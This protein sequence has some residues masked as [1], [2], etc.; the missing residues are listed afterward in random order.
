MKFICR[1]LIVS[2][3]MLPFQTLQAG[4]IGTGEAVAA[5]QAQAARA[6]V[7]SF[8]SRAEVASQLEALGLTA[9]NAKDRVGAL[10]DAEVANLAGRI[11]SLPA[12]AFG[13]LT[14]IFV[15]LICV[16]IGW[17]INKK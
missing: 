7:N 6:A 15:I 9:Q 16:L 1:M 12:G 13:T 17:N 8:V 11:D 4:M 10:T 2:M 5:A 3:L 14:I